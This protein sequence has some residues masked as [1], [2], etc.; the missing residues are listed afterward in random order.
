MVA[1]IIQQLPVIL[2]SDTSKHVHI[3]YTHIYQSAHMD[4]HT[5]THTHTRPHAHTHTRTHTHT[6]THTHAHTHTHT[7][8]CT[9]KHTHTHT[10]EYT[11][12][13]CTLPD[14]IMTQQYTL[15]VLTSLNRQLLI[16]G[17]CSPTEYGTTAQV[18]QHRTTPAGNTPLSTEIN[19]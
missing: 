8:T 14:W 9:H 10:I 3:Q 12:E 11:I 15:V 4:M 16:S 1:Q 19:T 6:H 18:Y 2:I 13:A 7:H 5:R 17:F